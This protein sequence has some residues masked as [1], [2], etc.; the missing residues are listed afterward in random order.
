VSFFIIVGASDVVATAKFF[1]TVP[2]YHFAQLCVIAGLQ[3]LLWQ[4]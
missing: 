2:T 3:N 4:F 1:A